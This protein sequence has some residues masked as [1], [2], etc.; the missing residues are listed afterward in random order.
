MSP[1]TALPTALRPQPPK[2]VTLPL[3]AAADRWGIDR[4]LLEEWAWQGRLPPSLA[5]WSHADRCWLFGRSKAAGRS[6]ERHATR[7]G[8]WLAGVDEQVCEVTAAWTDEIDSDGARC[9]R[10]DLVW[11]CISSPVPALEADSGDFATWCSDHPHGGAVTARHHANVSE[12]YQMLTAAGVPHSDPAYG[13]RVTV[14]WE[15]P[16]DW[17]PD[18]ADPRT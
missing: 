6:A 7:G 3:A 11:W 15:H 4:S 18:R 8:L 2:P 9:L 10:L 5:Q 13:T 12:W 1:A 17:Q 14:L 16:E